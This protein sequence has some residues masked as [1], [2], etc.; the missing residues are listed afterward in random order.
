MEHAAYMP[1]LLTIPR[2]RIQ[3]EQITTNT[4]KIVLPIHLIPLICHGLELSRL[5]L[6]IVMF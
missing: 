5:Q 4:S 1:P 2:I 3:F 6:E